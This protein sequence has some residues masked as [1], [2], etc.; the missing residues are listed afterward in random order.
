[1]ERL[2]G[3]DAT[4][5]YSETPSVHMHTLK[6]AVLDVPAAPESVFERFRSELDR[7]L[8]L[9][10]P[11]SL[12]ALEVPLGI[13][14]PV[15][16]VD[17]ELNIDRH[18]FQ[19]R[20]GAPG[21]RRELDRV[22]GEIASTPL[23]RDRPLWEI[24][25]LEGLDDGAVAFVAKVHHAMADGLASA[26]MLANVMVTGPDADAQRD[27][28]W[29]SRAPSELP[30]RLSLAYDAI[31]ETPQRVSEL[32]GLIGRTLDGARRVV[33]RAADGELER[34]RPFTAPKTPFNKTL[35]P[36][37]SFATT[38]VD[39]ERVKKIKSAL[40]VTLND[41]VLGVVGGA[42]LSFLES[43]GQSPDRSLLATVPVS[44][45]GLETG[46]RLQGN[47]LSNLFT[48]LCTH[49][50]DPAERVRRIHTTTRHAKDAHTQFGPEVMQSWAEYTPPGPYHW[51]FRA[52]SALRFA[53][54]I[55]PAANVIVS[56]VRGPAQELFL[57][58]ARIKEFYSV[59]PI[60]DG[61]GL[62]IT[63]WS[64]N[65]KMSFATLAYREAIPEPYL[66]SERLHDSLA[67]LERAAGL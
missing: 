54:R 13:H 65:G 28:G 49:V 18:L 43:R 17:P 53:D 4:F 15:W 7:R 14:H 47:R 1:M 59:G 38:A 27:E 55:R 12:R 30:S 3:L 22:V 60:L 39:L 58:G 9:L 19:R 16:V 21:S 26:A 23:R 33:G 52:Y 64:Y 20:I 50:A 44:V 51:G 61:L 62:N 67:E 6:V 25:M 10:P 45:P 32:P 11:F 2:S 34:V 42:L 24:W 29:A 5:L 8:H 37:R 40:E 48:S 35:G 56:N 66:I 57:S 41:V 63:A 31:K 36:G 46:Q